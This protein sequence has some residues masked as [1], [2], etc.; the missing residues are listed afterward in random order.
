MAADTIGLL[1]VLGSGSVHLV[2]ASLGG[3][4]AQTIAIEYPQR[5]RSLTSIMATTGNLAV[6]QPHP[7]TARRIFG[8]PQP[9]TR[10]EA[11][12]RRL[13]AARIIGSPGFPFDAE[14]AAERA[15]RAFDRRAFDPLAMMRQGAAVLASGD[16]T[17]RLRGLR[18]P[19]LV[20]HG[21]NDTLCDVSGGRATANAIPGAVLRVI[22][23][24]GHDL[25]NALWSDIAT[26]I[27][28]VVGR[29]EA[30]RLGKS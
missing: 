16:R 8:G 5:V 26:Q 13:E 1:D 12:E 19:T 24:M 4:V 28:T 29:G 25:P 30:A 3:F 27:S 17:A 20:I 23:G 21:A 2:G 11:I 10:A 15:G 7:E 9:T 14:A 6:G 18:I 22:D